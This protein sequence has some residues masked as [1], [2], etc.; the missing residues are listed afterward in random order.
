MCAVQMFYVNGQ[1]GGSLI[2]T[3]FLGSNIQLYE[4]FSSLLT[5]R[6]RDA[7]RYLSATVIV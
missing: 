7:G 6:A 2:Q 1:P 5:A 4:T 3:D